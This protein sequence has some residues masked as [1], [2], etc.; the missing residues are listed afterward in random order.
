MNQIAHSLVNYDPT[1]MTW[2]IS[3]NEIGRPKGVMGGDFYRD[4]QRFE[5]IFLTAILKIFNILDLG[6][7]LFPC[8][9]K[10]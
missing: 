9:H 3:D 8:A 10:I 7:C 5:D 1:L 2:T 4:R 6:P